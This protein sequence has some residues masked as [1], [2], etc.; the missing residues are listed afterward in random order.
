MKIIL[1][2]LLLLLLLAFTPLNAY[3]YS[4]STH[5]DITDPNTPPC[6]GECCE[7]PDG[8]PPDSCPSTPS[9]KLDQN[10]LSHKVIELTLDS[11]EVKSKKLIINLKI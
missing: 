9:Y 5:E 6:T 1:R 3:N 8:C 10:K 11:I 4:W 2:N 7:Q